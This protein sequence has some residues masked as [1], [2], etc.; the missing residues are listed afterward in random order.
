M[1]QVF[2]SYLWR[3]SAPQM[4]PSSA[5]GGRKME[6]GGC[7]C[8]KHNVERYSDWDSLSLLAPKA[9]L[10]VS[11][12]LLWRASQKS[13][14]LPAASK[15][16]IVP[17]TLRSHAA[18]GDPGSPCRSHLQS[19]DIQLRFGGNWS[20]VYG[21][22]SLKYKEFLLEDGE[23]VT[24]VSGTRKLCLTSLSFTTNKGRV[25]TFGVRRGLS[26]N[27]SGGSDKYLVTVNGLY[28]PGLC[29]NGMGFKWKNIHDD[30][31]D[32]D[33]D[34]EDDDDEHDDDNEEDHGDKDNDKDHDDDHDDD[35]DDKEDD[36]EEDVDDERD[37]KDDDEEEDDNDK[38]NDK[39][40]GEG[41]GD[42]DD[43]DDEDD[44]KDDDGGSGND[45]D[46]GDDDEDDDGGDD[47]NGDEEEE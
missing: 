38:E 40:D 4:T 15:C 33:D 47:D 37:D 41:S 17:H 43:N 8:G 19:P 42:D 22:R 9:I 24:Q 26:F 30:F 2:W 44:D 6:A 12:C 16:Q 23:H 29:L 21:S 46:D 27:E 45:D 1:V 13:H 7:V 11:V 10:T 25:V 32:N 36:N 14:H 39:D 35:D 3:V 28:A 34:K 31:D 18:V 20:D 5:E